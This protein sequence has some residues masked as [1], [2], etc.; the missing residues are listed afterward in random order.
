MLFIEV[1]SDTQQRWISKLP[2][3]P[4]KEMVSPFRKTLRK[5]GIGHSFP[6]LE[7]DTRM[8]FPQ[9]TRLEALP[10]TRRTLD[11]SS[12]KKFRLTPRL[13]G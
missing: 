4:G 2:N 12:L 7:S 11:K 3:I 13:I 8:G 9:A 10:L 6:F 5:I 1:L